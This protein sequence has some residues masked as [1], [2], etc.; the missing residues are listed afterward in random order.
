MSYDRGRPLVG[1]DQD[2]PNDEELAALSPAMA[3]LVPRQ[4][5]FCYFYI[6]NGGHG[7]NAVRSAGYSSKSPNYCRVMAHKLLHSKPILQAIHATSWAF[8]HSL[9][10]PA[11]SALSDVLRDPTHRDRVRAAALILDRTGFHAQSQHTVVVENHNTLML[12][13]PSAEV[14]QQLVEAALKVG[15]ENMPALPA[16]KD[17]ILDAEILDDGT[18][19]IEGPEPSSAEGIES[20]IDPE[21]GDIEQLLTLE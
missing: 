14:M 18:E 16:P 20:P 15:I 12:G 3:A 11:L 19:I 21:I 13:K 6:S 5:A 2:L 17:E 7:A 8:L 1:F 10:T 4:R 9:T